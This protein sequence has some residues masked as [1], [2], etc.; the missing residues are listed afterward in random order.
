MTDRQTGVKTLPTL[1]LCFIFSELAEF[2]ANGRKLHENERNRADRGH[3]A[4]APPL[5]PPLVIITCKKNQK[6][7]NFTNFFAEL[8]EFLA[9]GRLPATKTVTI[10]QNPLV[11]SCHVR[12][13]PLPEITWFKD[14][15]A[16]G[17]QG[18]LYYVRIIQQ[19]IET[20]SYNVTSSLLFQG[21]P[22]T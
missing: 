22:I 13:R 19:P 16:I 7:H 6:N 3:A 14:D 12:G 18:G 21:Q 2:L 17:D 10:T 15:A 1:K 5:D 11:I 4:L 8:P 20:F 9:N